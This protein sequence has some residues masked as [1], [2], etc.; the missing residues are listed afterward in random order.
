MKD[1]THHG[2]K[3]WRIYLLYVYDFLWLSCDVLRALWCFKFF[4]CFWHGFDIIPFMFSYILIWE[5]NEGQTFTQVQNAPSKPVRLHTR[6]KRAKAGCGFGGFQYGL[7]TVAHSRLEQQRTR[8]VEPVYQ[9]DR[10]QYKA[11]RAQCP[12]RGQEWRMGPAPPSVRRRVGR[13]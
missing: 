4:V 3:A 10:S 2:P 1:L 5:S 7:H 11:R 6:P 12:E 8:A 9:S 13:C